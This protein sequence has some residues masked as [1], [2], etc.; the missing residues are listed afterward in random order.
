[1]IFDATQY[2]EGAFNFVRQLNE[3]QPVLAVGVFVP[4]VDYASLWS[5]ASAAGAATGGIFIPLLEEADTQIIEDNILKFQSECQKN[6]ITYRVHKDFFDFALPALKKETQF[7]DLAVIS[8]E[9]YYRNVSESSQFEYLKD[10]LQSAE[11]PVVIVPESYNFPLS[12]ILA[13]DGSQ[14]SIFAIKQFAY[15]FPEWTNQPTLLVY[16]DENEDRDFPYKEYIVELATQHFKN[17]SFYKLDVDPKRYF[18]TWIRERPSSILVCG[19]F[20]RSG[21]S[22]MFKRSFV[23]DIIRDHKVPVFIAH[24]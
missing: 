15:L 1:M 9:L 5:Y 3:I 12:C 6:G 11:C 23:T 4:Q 10:A 8:G 18:T 24:K 20:G 19:S 16:A 22:L 13:Y 17:L 7:A 14:E 2:S 21:L